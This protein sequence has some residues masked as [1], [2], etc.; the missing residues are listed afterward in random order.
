[1]SNKTQIQN[2]FTKIILLNFFQKS[3]LGTVKFSQEKDSVYISSEYTKNKV[4]ESYP[5]LCVCVCSDR[6][7]QHIYRVGTYVKVMKKE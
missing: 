6:S 2:Y 7:P 5:V 3:Y 1:M 4:R